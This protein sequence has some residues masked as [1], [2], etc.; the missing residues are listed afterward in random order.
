[1]TTFRLTFFCLVTKIH[2]VYVLH[3]FLSNS[4]K[5]HAKACLD[6]VVASKENAQSQRGLVGK[7]QHWVFITLACT[8]ILGWV[9]VPVKSAALANCLL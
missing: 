3:D 1:M 7:S 9:Q 6:L 5:V 4:L 8:L 2:W